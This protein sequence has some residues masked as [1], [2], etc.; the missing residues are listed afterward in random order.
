MTQVLTDITLANLETSKK[1]FKVKLWSS[2]HCGMIEYINPH[3]HHTENVH[4]IILYIDIS[5]KSDKN[6]VMLSI[7][8]K[9]LKYS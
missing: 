6:A 2:L 1:G 5:N 3:H 7:T 9:R 4:L 8:R